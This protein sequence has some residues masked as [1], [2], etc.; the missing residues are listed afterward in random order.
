MA[1]IPAIMHGVSG[2]RARGP[3][4]TK[5]LGGF[6]LRPFR[7]RGRDRKPPRASNVAGRG[8][9]GGWRPGFSP[10]PDATRMPPVPDAY[11]VVPAGG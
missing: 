3:E 8:H 2:P 4:I 1:G 9:R 10:Y 11:P 7:A 5:H 6:S